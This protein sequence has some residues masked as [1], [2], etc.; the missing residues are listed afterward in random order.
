MSLTSLVAAEIYLRLM[1]MKH[2]RLAT[3]LQL[4]WPYTMVLTV[5][6]LGTAYGSLERFK[7]SL[8]IEDPVLYLF[9]SSII[10][11][12]AVSVI[13]YT[14][15]I[16]TWHRWIGTLPYIATA[17]LKPAAFLMISGV[18]TSLFVALIEVA[19]II[20]GVV[21]VSG[22]H[23][24][25][26]MLLVFLVLVLGM[27]PLI[28]V[29]GALAMASLVLREEGHAFSFVNPL[30]LLVSGVFYP[31]ELLPRIL[32]ALS[33]VVPVSY[34]VEASKLIAG[35]TQTPMGELILVIIVIALMAV[36]YNSGG[37]AGVLAMERL[38]RR[39]GAWD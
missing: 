14:A 18:A 8:G 10:A 22:A 36:G 26:K 35:L 23:G 1:W 12:T 33:G 11:F 37:A 7:Q 15:S 34:I 21:L 32:K 31:I 28:G 16:A 27:M 38:V 39:R 2:N 29:A 4:L 6:G 24:A 5:F 19:S 3:T 20:P 17:S 30:L 9:A 13:D 25:L